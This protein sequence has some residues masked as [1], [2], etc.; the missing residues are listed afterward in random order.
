MDAK[1]DELKLDIKIIR[2][3]ICLGRENKQCGQ[4]I[5]NTIYQIEY[6]YQQE[7]MENEY[8]KEVTDRDIIGCLL[9]SSKYFESNR[10]TR[11]MPSDFVR[12]TNKKY[13]VP[14]ICK[15]EIEYIKKLDYKVDKL[16]LNQYNFYKIL[17][18]MLLDKYIKKCF[19]L[20]DKYYKKLCKLCQEVAVNLMFQIGT[21]GTNH[22]NG[23]QL[24]ASIILSGYQKIQ[25]IDENSSNLIHCLGMK[26]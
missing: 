11:L 6:L 26:S 8:I 18:E 4:T 1:L 13:C 22:E 5:L 9:L 21:R 7:S 23:K 19:K 25:I 16:L 20:N 10:Q 2:R 3:I 14:E 12:I 15:I 17:T 24:A